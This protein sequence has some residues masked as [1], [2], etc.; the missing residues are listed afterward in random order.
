MES[1]NHY[2]IDARHCDYSPYT[3]PEISPNPDNGHKCPVCDEIIPGNRYEQYFYRVYDKEGATHV[4]YHPECCKTRYTQCK[5]HWN[6][7]R[8]LQCVNKIQTQTKSANK[9]IY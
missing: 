8:F 2:N 7:S 6:I 5:E 4:D 1:D 3:A 9:L